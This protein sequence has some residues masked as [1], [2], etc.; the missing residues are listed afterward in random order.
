M[1]TGWTAMAQPSREYASSD[2][3]DSLP[4]MGSIGLP[5]LIVLFLAVVLVSVV[6][7]VVV[8]LIKATTRGGA[9]RQLLPCRACGKPIS[10]RA[11]S[12]PSCGE[13]RA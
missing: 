1:M 13:P 6:V 11:V 9:E 5:E 8:R 3:F 7:I 4:R 10:P 2:A 12:C